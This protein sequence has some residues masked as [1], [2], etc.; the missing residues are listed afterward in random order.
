MHVGIGDVVSHLLGGL[1]AVWLALSVVVQFT[2]ANRF[3]DRMIGFIRSWDRLA[4]LPAW[5]FFAPRPGQTDIHLLF[6]DV[7]DALADAAWREAIPERRM[8]YR[9]PLWD[10]Q[11]RARKILVD[12][13]QGLM[14]KARGDT[15]GAFRLTGEYICLLNYIVHLET[16]PFIAYRQFAIVETTGES[17]RDSLNVMFVSDIHPVE[18]L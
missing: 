18:R 13:T 10:P 3:L 14:E 6:R 5:T 16:S 12:F 4:L 9:D 1:F 17:H 7:S 2:G 11:K 15:A 8:K